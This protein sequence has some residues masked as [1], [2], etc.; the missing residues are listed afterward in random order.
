MSIHDLALSEPT[1][2]L[3]LALTHKLK[4]LH[5]FRAQSQSSPNQ[6]Y[7]C[8]GTVLKGLPALLKGAKIAGH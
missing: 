3:S 5:S 6:S 1:P 7:F 8:F 4:V 2:T